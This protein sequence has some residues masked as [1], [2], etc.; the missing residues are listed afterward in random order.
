M[1]TKGSTKAEPASRASK[2]AAV[3]EIRVKLNESDAAVL[4]EYRGLSVGELAQLRQ[5]LRGG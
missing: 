5:S 3:D 4:S 1:D 2:N